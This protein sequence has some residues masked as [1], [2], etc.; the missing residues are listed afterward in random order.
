MQEGGSELSGVREEDA[1][2]TDET[3]EST[4]VTEE[5]TNGETAEDGERGESARETVER[6]L[7][8]SRET[9]GTDATKVEPAKQPKNRQ[10]REAVEV[11]DPPPNRFT[12]EEKQLY[13]KLPKQLRQSISKMVGDHQAYFTKQT[14]Q[15]SAAQREASAVVET[16]RPYLHAHP[17]LLQHGF[18]ESKLV[19]S[20]IAAHQKLTDPKTALEAYLGLGRDIGIDNDTLEGIYKAYGGEK[21]RSN[22]DISSHPQFRAV[23]E[24]LNRVK[25]YT[26]SLQQQS[27]NN[28]VSKIVAEMDAVRNEKD[29]AGN[30]LYPKL[31]DGDFLERVKPLVSALRGTMPNASY[32]DLLKRAYFSLEGN[33]AQHNQTS[34]PRNNNNNRA[35]Q[36]AVSVRGRS[37]PS[38]GVQEDAIPAEALKDARATVA[39]ALKQYRR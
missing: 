11:D 1:G 9:N 15:L 21:K 18:T 33:S 10:D 8:E 7:R 28:T 29:T 16:V 3:T 6:I 27:F 25:S 36:A 2:V 12:A 4:E 20:L 17:E 22:V 38:L 32:G 35:T 14:Q 37:A 26:D 13:S 31:H 5:T 30:Y 39:W 19:G 23:Q 34:L 24:E